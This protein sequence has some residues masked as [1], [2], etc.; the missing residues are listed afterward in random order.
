MKTLQELA[1]FFGMIIAVD[2][3]KDTYAYPSEPEI[4]TYGDEWQTDGYWFGGDQ[5]CHYIPN[6]MVK[7]D[8]KW[9]ASLTFPNIPEGK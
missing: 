3:G 2:E 1:D 8:G 6:W 5:E 4:R 9:E 7:Y